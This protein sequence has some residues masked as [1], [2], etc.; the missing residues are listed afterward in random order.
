MST[1]KSPA[2]QCSKNYKCS[3][4]TQSISELWESIY[5]LTKGRVEDNCK[6]EDHSYPMDI[7]M[8]QFKTLDVLVQGLKDAHTQVMS[9]LYNDWDIR[10][11]DRPNL[12]KII[13]RRYKVKFDIDDVDVSWESSRKGYSRYA[14]FNITVS[15]NKL[16]CDVDKSMY[17]SITQAESGDICVSMRGNKS[18]DPS[19]VFNEYELDDLIGY[20]LYH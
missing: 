10:D 2:S 12:I 13:Q 17:L 9:I 8:R 16:K 6:I 18:R 7:R 11:I 20:I 14:D 1:D 15:P 19:E 3:D 4:E 5:R